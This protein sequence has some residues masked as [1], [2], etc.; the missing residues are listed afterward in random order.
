MTVIS[1]DSVTPKDTKL[2]DT[3]TYIDFLEPFILCFKNMAHENIE[4]NILLLDV[5]GNGYKHFYWPV[6]LIII[7]QKFKY[8]CK[9]VLSCE[10]CN[11]TLVVLFCGLMIL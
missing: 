5:S 8:V 11:K 7:S 10:V 3:K 6:T 9:C 4:W 2:E 1:R